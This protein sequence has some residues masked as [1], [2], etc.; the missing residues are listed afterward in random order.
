MRGPAGDKVFEYQDLFKQSVLFPGFP[1]LLAASPQV[2]TGLA[3]WT[4][5][6][7]SRRF[8]DVDDFLTSL[9]ELDCRSATSSGLHAGTLTS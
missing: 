6:T 9:R 2:C 7:S 4:L 1:A 3:K 8:V 5:G